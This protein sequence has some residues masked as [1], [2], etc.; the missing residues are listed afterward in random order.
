MQ[1]EETRYVLAVRVNL[2]P[3]SIGIYGICA[4][5]AEVMKRFNMFMAESTERVLAEGTHKLTEPRFTKWGAW[6]RGSMVAR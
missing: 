2:H 3:V 6:V 5:L 4:V 1:M